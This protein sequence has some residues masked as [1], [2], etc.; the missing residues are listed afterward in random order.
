MSEPNESLPE[1]A[2]GIPG[3]RYRVVHLRTAEYND[4]A[5]RAAWQAKGS[6]VL[7]PMEGHVPYIRCPI[8]STDE[9]E[10]EEKDCAI[11]GAG[12]CLFRESP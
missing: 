5:V 4:P 3:S 12:P 6:A 2:R 9:P 11:C 8:C 1:S 7:G 10:P